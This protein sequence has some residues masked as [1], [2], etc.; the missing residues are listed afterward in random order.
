HQGLLQLRGNGSFVL[1][2]PEGPGPSGGSYTLVDGR[3]T[4][5]SDVCGSAVGEYDVTVSGPAEP[6]KAAL[7]FTA[8][9]DDCGARRRYLT[10]DPWIYA[11]S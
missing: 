10:I 5:R 7:T 6:G 4:V 9:R 3:L 8:V 2:V 11:N 1:I